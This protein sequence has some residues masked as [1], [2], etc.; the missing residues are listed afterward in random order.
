MG[1]NEIIHKLNNNIGTVFCFFLWILVSLNEYIWL[2][3][4]KYPQYW[5]AAGH[6]IESIRMF[7]ILNKGLFAYPDII[8]DATYYPPLVT[9]SGTPFYYFFGPSINI[10]TWGMNCIFLGILIFSIY[11]L[12]KNIKNVKTG[13]LSA[14]IVVSFPFIGESSKIFM[15]DVPLVAL[16]SLSLYLLLKTELFSNRNFSIFFGIS[17]GL[18]MLTKWTFAL[19]LAG[20]L[21]YYSILVYQNGRLDKNNLIYSGKNFLL[22]TVIGGLIAG[23]WYLP[24]L[25]IIFELFS[26]AGIETFEPNYFIITIWMASLYFTLLFLIMNCYLLYAKRIDQKIFTLLLSMIIPF[27]ILSLQSNRDARFLSPIL[28]AMALIISIGIFSLKNVTLKRVILFLSILFALALFISSSYGTPSIPFYKELGLVTS[29]NIGSDKIPLFGTTYNLIR[30]P[31]SDNWKELEIYDTLVQDSEKN[32]V[33][34]GVI[35]ESG[36]IIGPLI[37]NAY[38]DNWSFNLYE[39][40]YDPYSFFNCQYVLTFKDRKGYWGPDDSR[41]IYEKGMFAQDLFDKYSENFVLMKTISLP[42]DSDLLIYKK[43]MNGDNV[44]NISHPFNI[45]FSDKIRFLG[46]NMERVNTNTTKEL[47]LIG[48]ITNTYKITYYWKCLEPMDKNYMIFVHFIDNKGNIIF[49]QDHNPVYGT[50]PTSDWIPGTI[51]QESYFVSPSG[52][53]PDGTYSMGIGFY[54]TSGEKLVPDNGQKDRYDGNRV[55]IGNFSVINNQTDFY[56]KMPDYLKK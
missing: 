42:D 19:F 28:P 2:N 15:L 44:S 24:H 56:K 50:Y 17:L 39:G 54:T 13:I 12:G 1:L 32:M 25:K 48:R 18:G 40:G 10:G 49:G 55:L 21:L 14:I 20:P 47:E 16:V 4:N 35:P 52:N 33:S 27:I 5:D 51:Y 8:R 41:H 34:I 22:S 7:H 43:Q 31:N 6:F 3:I 29:I 38:I 37:Y 26:N 45:T 46:Y 23:I 36:V 9:L 53:V 11:S 30:I